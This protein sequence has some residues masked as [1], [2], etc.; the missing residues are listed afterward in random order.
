MASLFV[1]DIDYHRGMDPV[2]EHLVAHR[3]HL[4][5][6]YAAGLFLASGRKEPRTGGIIIATGTRPE[7]EEAVA[8]D[9][10]VVHDAARYVV[11][12]FRPTMTG[13]ELAT[14]GEG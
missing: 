7:V 8:R 9:P 4:A 14:F 1:I 5:E 6:C 3:A 13:P 10:F 11:T 12:E 2:D